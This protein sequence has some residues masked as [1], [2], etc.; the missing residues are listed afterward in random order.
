MA[1]VNDIPRSTVL[2]HVFFDGFFFEIFVVAVLLVGPP[3]S[4]APDPLTEPEMPM[5][6]TVYLLLSATEEGLLG[7]E[8]Q[9]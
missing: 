2:A 9:S 4:V 8:K 5:P 7:R 1:P 6:L 3:A